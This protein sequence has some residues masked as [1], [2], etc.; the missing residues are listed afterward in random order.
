MA[1][2]PLTLSNAA[3]LISS[4]IE[5]VI[6]STVSR[7]ELIIASEGSKRTV[8]PRA[9]QPVAVVQVVEVGRSESRGTPRRKVSEV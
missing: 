4:L 8:Q 6:R 9:I 2:K 3:V 1:N 7:K 5:V